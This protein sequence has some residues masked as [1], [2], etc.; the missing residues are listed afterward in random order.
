MPRYTGEPAHICTDATFDDGTITPDDGVTGHVTIWTKDWEVV[1]AETPMTWNADKGRW[2]YVWDTEGAGAG[3]YRAKARLEGV[4]GASIW[5]Y[6][7]IL[8]KQDPAPV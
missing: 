4:D 2:E 8:L 1:L 7:R 5:E 6:V 3:N